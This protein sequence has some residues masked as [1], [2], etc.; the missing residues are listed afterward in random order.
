LETFHA[1]SGSMYIV[2]HPD[3]RTDITFKFNHLIPLGVYSLWDVTNPDPENFADRPL[4]DSV[5]WADDVRDDGL[6]GGTAGM[7]VHAFRAD[8]CGR[9]QVTVNMSDHRPGEEFLLDYHANDG[10]VKGQDV[11][12]G[13]LWGEFPAFDAE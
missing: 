4:A 2:E 6:F 7:G 12:P 5:T 10:G 9:A 3:M 1:A 8:Q 11:F 13:A